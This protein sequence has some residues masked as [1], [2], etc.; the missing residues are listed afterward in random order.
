MSSVTVPAAA[1]ATLLVAAK[2]L[3]AEARTRSVLQ[4]VAF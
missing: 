2:D 1:R 3:R 4:G